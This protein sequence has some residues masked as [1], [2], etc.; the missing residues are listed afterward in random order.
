MED[1][2]VMILLLKGRI[3]HHSQRGS[4]AQLLRAWGPGL[5]LPETQLCHQSITCEAVDRFLNLS[6]SQF[7]LV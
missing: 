6:S 2:H 4:T 3:H 5:T 1:I 7:T